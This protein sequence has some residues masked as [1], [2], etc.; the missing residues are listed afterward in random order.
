[1]ELRKETKNVLPMLTHK[2]TNYKIRIINY[3]PREPKWF[4]V[5]IKLISAYIRWALI[6]YKNFARHYGTVKDKRDSLLSKTL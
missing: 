5:P 6:T 1:M 4:M 3:I 2:K